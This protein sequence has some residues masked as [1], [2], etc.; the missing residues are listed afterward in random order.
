MKFIV[1][2]IRNDSQKRQKRQK[3][4]QKRHIFSWRALEI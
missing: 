2:L 3:R 1:N 4:G